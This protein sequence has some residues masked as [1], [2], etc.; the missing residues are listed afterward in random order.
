MS[1]S[2][3]SKGLYP[4]QG[5]LREPHGFPWKMLCMARLCPSIPPR[6]ALNAGEY[7]ELELLQTLERG[8]SDA[9]PA[10]LR[11]SRI[12]DLGGNF[13]MLG[14]LAHVLLLTGIHVPFNH[15]VMPRTQN[16]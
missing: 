7:A 5:S 11:P 2:E 16:F 12:I 9:Y 6:A 14:N 1:P 4:P 3:S 10:A 13:R 8:L 15:H